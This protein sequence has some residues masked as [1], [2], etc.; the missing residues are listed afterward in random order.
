M[1]D[2]TLE[3]WL[4][5]L[6]GRAAKP[7]PNYIVSKFPGDQVR[8]AYM[9]VLPIQSEESVHRLLRAFLGQTRTINEHD[10][11][12]VGNRLPRS[13]IARNPG[14][15]EATPTRTDGPCPRWQPTSSPTASRFPADA[16]T[17]SKAE[18]SCCRRDCLDSEKA[19]R[20]THG[21]DHHVSESSRDTVTFGS[22]A[23]SGD[24]FGHAT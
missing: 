12:A 6:D 22:A 16:A 5:V 1:P 14:H 19:C 23:R 4:A 3:E 18:T 20:G 24:S 9:T 7:S 8:D 21:D 11:I 10:H 17:N 15:C 2:Y 13:E